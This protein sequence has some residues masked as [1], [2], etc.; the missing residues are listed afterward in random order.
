MADYYSTEITN[1]MAA[2]PTLNVAATEGLVRFRQATYVVPTGAVAAAKTIAMIP[3][4][5]GDLLL[6][7]VVSAESGALASG[8]ILQVGDGTTAD[9]YAEA[10]AND[11]DF[12]FGRPAYA[13]KYA[14]KAT[15]DHYLTL[16]TKTG[17]AGLVAGKTVKVV[18]MYVPTGNA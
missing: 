11:G 2:A 5:K 18:L 4:K 17:S 9:L 3:V 14:Q 15:A 16:T 8:C 13:N 12:E 7:G 10:S 6:G 1:R